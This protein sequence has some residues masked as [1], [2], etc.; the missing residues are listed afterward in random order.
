MAVCVKVAVA[1][2]EVGVMVGAGGVA[3]AHPANTMSEKIAN[4]L[5]TFIE[6]LPVYRPLKPECK[7]CIHLTHRNAIVG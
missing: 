4:G 2:T 5:I 7:Y 3:V 6:N 1:G